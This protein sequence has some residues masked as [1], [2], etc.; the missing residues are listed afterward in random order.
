MPIDTVPG[1][2]SCVG[3]EAPDRRVQPHR[4]VAGLDVEPVPATVDERLERQ[5]EL[6][7]WGSSEL[8]AAASARSTWPFAVDR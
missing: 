7:V 5:V 3:L 4:L 8:T 1:W 2:A 6:T